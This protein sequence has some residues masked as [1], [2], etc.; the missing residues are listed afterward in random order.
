MNIYVIYSLAVLFLLNIIITAIRAG[1][2]NI[3]YGKLLAM[4]EKGDDLKNTISLI[5]NRT[6]TRAAF[7]LSQIIIRFSMI[8]LELFL[9]VP[10]MSENVSLG[11]LVGVLFVSSLVIWVLEFFVEYWILRSP[12]EW[13]IKLTPLAQTVIKL[14]SPLLA[15]PFKIY[16]NGEDD[17]FITITEE[18]L[19]SMVKASEEAGEIEQDEATLIRSVFRFDDTLV[20]EVMIPRV[21]IFGLEVNTPIEEASQRL[22]D[23]G[24]SRVP[25]YEEQ[26]DNILGFLYTKDMLKVWLS[27]EE[28]ENKS[29][30][31]LLRDV[32][33]VPEFKKVDEVLRDMQS[34]HNHIAIVVDEYG[35]I[36]GL[37]TL[38]DIIEEI[39][40]EIQDE[41]DDIEEALYEEISLGKYIFQGHALLEEVN[42]I[43]GGKLPVGE[44]DTLGGLIFNRIKDVP[45][46]GE[47]IIE[48]GITLIVEEMEGRRIKKVLVLNPSN[49][50]SNM[51]A[52]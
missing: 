17:S 37:I 35:G 31:N 3:R 18:E 26:T 13:A 1:I 34:N 28:N 20:K 52:E 47:K 8:A 27:G 44:A 4:Q 40:G 16:A 48:E 45:S 50:L 24:F 23:T 15:L 41:Y 12:G 39:F 43:I 51:E 25:V 21:D 6:H 9:I 22:L 14:I 38:E 30:R 46:I 49:L 19:K 7:K 29:L 5:E 33:Y 2:L 42:N 36:S 10:F 11:F 32:K